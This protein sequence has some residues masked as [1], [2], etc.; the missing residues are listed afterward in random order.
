MEI[1]QNIKDAMAPD[2][3][4]LIDDMVLPN[5]G[6]HWQQAQLDMLMMAA[7]GARERTQEQWNQLL[8]SAGLK[9]NKVHTYTESLQDSII[10]AV[11]A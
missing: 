9:I 10:E 11:A 3:Y 6:V 7:L 8:Q 2:S 5:V 4:I 1:L